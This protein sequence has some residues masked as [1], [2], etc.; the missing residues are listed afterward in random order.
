MSE[1]LKIEN[2]ENT[3][4]YSEKYFNNN[5]KEYE[6]AFKD[7]AESAYMVTIPVEKSIKINNIEIKW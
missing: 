7:W 4:T 2:Y 1:K 3:I 6:K 5:I